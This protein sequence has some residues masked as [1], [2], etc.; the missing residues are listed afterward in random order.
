[1]NYQEIWV[2]IYE[3]LK[4]NGGVA[5][6]IVAENT[7]GSPGRKGFKMAIA[8]DGSCCGTI[9]GGI[10]EYKLVRKARDLLKEGQKEVQYIP[11]IHQKNNSPHQSGMICAGSQVILLYT[12]FP[13]E[14]SVFRDLVQS[15]QSPSYEV[16]SLMAKPDGI[17]LKQGARAEGLRVHDDKTWTYQENIEPSM[18]VYIVGGGHV[19][20]A[21][22]QVLSVLDAYVTVF[23]H[24]EDLETVRHNP[25]CDQMI[26][27]PY[28][29]IGHYI[30]EGKN[31][32]GLVVSTSFKTD[33]AGLRQ[34]LRKKLRYLGVMGSRAKIEKILANLEASGFTHSQLQKIRAPI[35]LN[36]KSR[37][38][39]E[40]GISIAAELVQEKNAEIKI[41][42]KIPLPDEQ[43]SAF[44]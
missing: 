33:E 25:Y 5:L 20:F 24:R 21:V 37:T 36:I 44:Y 14:L 2:F 17:R 1:M 7:S 26:V 42:K 29:K 27:G 4:K 19:G 6:M 43:F 10:M 16:F 9:G 39:A 13:D 18:F 34:L 15:F 31:S 30:V 38:A 3:Q 35:G 23:D 11:Q 28:E 32:Y 8:E 41:A 22:S 40:I 12:F